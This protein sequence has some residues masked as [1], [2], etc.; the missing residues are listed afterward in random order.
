MS[1]VTRTGKVWMTAV[2]LCGITLSIAGCAQQDP[3]SQ[4]Q[5][6]LATESG[7]EDVLPS[8][9][10]TSGMDT[11]SSREVGTLGAL[12]YFVTAYSV[13]GACL[14]IVDS[15]SAASSSACGSDLSGL[16]TSSS[17]VGGARIVTDSDEVPP[18]WTRL[19]DFLIVN[20]DATS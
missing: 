8:I 4:I 7:P 19:A 2:A 10:E 12:R 11:K 6:F 20:P 17:E 9:L 3:T 1:K 15:K 18:G 5:S 16:R 13:N 14:V